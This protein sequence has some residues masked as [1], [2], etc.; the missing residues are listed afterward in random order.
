[1]DDVFRN[2]TFP[3]L[4]LCLRLMQNIYCLCESLIY[5]SSSCFFSFLTDIDAKSPIL[6]D[7]D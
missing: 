4:P 3:E 1:M 5:L 7:N 2:Q 6:I